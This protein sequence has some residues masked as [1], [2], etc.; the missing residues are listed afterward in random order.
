MWKSED[1]GVTFKTQSV[2]P[3]IA[4]I[5]RGETFTI[6]GTAGAIGGG[7]GA[8]NSGPSAGVYFQDLEFAGSLIPKFYSVV[9]SMLNSSYFLSANFFLKVKDYNEIDFTLPIYLDVVIKG[10]GNI[11]GYF[12]CNEIKQFK[13]NRY[14]TTEVELIKI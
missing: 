10:F 2:K 9:L 5:T 1:G 3:R 6:K 13:I 4:Y 11:K 7:S 12:Y 8:S 14:E